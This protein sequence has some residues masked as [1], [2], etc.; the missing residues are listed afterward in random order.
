MKR[1]VSF[2][3]ISIIIHLL[4][5]IWLPMV[6]PEPKKLKKN[7]RISLVVDKRSTKKKPP[8][9]PEEKEKGQIVELPDPEEAK[10]PKDADYLAEKNHSVEKETKTE[11]YR[12]NPEVIADKVTPNE[13][14]KFEDVL[15]VQAQE[16]SSGAQ[17]GNECEA[18]RGEREKQGE[19]KVE[20]REN[21][22]RQARQR[23][24]DERLEDE[25]ARDGVVDSDVLSLL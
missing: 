4:L 21:N 20:H 17:V 16:H 25:V 6:K 24:T 11:D 2:L 8:P 23:G 18:E 9:K 15:D 13:K 1:R 5:L 3:L 19:R 22:E 12:I 14:L 7:K 10:K